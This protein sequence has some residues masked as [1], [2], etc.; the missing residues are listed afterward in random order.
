M[1][2]RQIEL[3]LSVPVCAWCEARGISPTVPVAVTHGICPRHM[4]ELMVEA[5]VEHE[6]PQGDRRNRPGQAEPSMRLMRAE[7]LLFVG[8][9]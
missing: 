8:A 3:P 5:G 2:A 4:H 1:I 7:Q 6:L 9:V